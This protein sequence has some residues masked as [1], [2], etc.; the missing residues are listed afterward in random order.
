MQIKSLH[1]PL[2]DRNLRV[3][4][5]ARISNNKELLETSIAEQVK[6][7]TALILKHSNWDFAGI[8]PD[9][10]KSGTSLNHRENFM[11]M[12]EN[13]RLGLIDIILVKSIS[14]FARNLIDLLQIVREFRNLGIEI[15]F[16]EQEISSLDVKAD[17]MITICAKF[18]EEEALTVSENVKWRYTKNM[19]DGKYSIPH[20][21]YGYRIIDGKITIVEEEAKWIKQMYKLCLEGCGSSLIIRYLEENKVVS[22]TGGTWGHNTICSILRNEKYAGDCLIQKTITIRPG[23]RI[24]HRNRG[25]EDM[26]L[27]RNGHP[28]I[29]DR[30][31]WN[32]V[33]EELNA[34]CTK[35]RAESDTHI[36]T[37]I[38]TG[39]VYCPYCGSNYTL[40]TNH[41]YGASGKKE[42]KFLICNSNRET[43]KCKSENIPAEEFK[44]GIMLLTEK[45]K[46][47]MPQF[48]EL[49]IKGFSDSDREN[50]LNRI[51]GIDKK[52]TELKEKLNG[53]TDKFD[54]YSR[55]ISNECMSEIT[56]LTMERLKLE[57]EILVTNSAEARTRNVIK[58]F[59]SV[60]S[61][62]ESFDQFDFKSL[63]SRAIVKTK[64]EVILVIG[65][66]DVSK[67]PLTI[68]GELK[69]SIKYR[70]KITDYVIN[71][72]VYV[73]I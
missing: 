18:A 20:N 49:L 17:Q 65:N 66:S 35:F 12:I 59:N 52:L 69:V 40:K 19:K 46:L 21:L 36:N 61:K 3:A 44:K 64:S 10:G 72:G 5:Y 37:S 67:L 4:A 29:I 39:F 32:A 7:Y 14:R 1:P 9:D 8:Y 73:N 24:S 15:Y 56:K 57:N 42:K 58:A 22:P 34:R 50:K 11:T 25:E 70:V 43:K 54:D 2:K 68:E 71:F 26:M 55:A 38:F 62:I 47:N 27:V 31:T 51:S 41:Y 13:A 23:A 6:H 45:I 60:P 63:Y 53:Y 30:E 28:A 16:E 33:Q 48:K